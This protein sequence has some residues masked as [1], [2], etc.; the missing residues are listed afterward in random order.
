M[1]RLL[2]DIPTHISSDDELADWVRKNPSLFSEAM[3]LDA[4]Q[5]DDRA[6]V[7]KVSISD[8]TVDGETVVI[9]Y[10]YDYSAYYGCRD[11]NHANTSD[12]EIIVGTRQGN[13]LSFERF[14]PR[15]RRSTDE[16]F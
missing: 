5:F 9:Q 12:E 10:E 4:S 16:E 1:N 15:E 2:I 6:T 8:V 11:M 14:K 3:D 13:I 7:D